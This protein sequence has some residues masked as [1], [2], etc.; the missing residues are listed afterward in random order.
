MCFL[1]DRL[2]LD[3]LQSWCCVGNKTR[4]RICETRDYNFNLCDSDSGGIVL[5]VVAVVQACGELTWNMRMT[6]TSRI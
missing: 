1:Q 3:E 2:F 4:V 6:S 5:T